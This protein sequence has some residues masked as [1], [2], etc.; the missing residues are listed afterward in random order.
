[1]REEWGKV[2]FQTFHDHIKEVRRRLLWVIL[3]IGVS[4]GIGYALRIPLIN[5]LQHP[6]GAPLYYTSPAGSFNFAIKISMIIGMFVALPVIIYQLIRFLEPA[7]PMRVKKGLMAKVIGSS[8]LLALTGIAFGYFYMIPMSLKFFAGY[9][10]AHIQPLISANE[11]L[12]YIINNLIIFALVFQIPLIV[13]FINRIKPLKPSKL[14]HY[15][16]HVVV[17]SFALA[18]ILPFTYDPISQFIVAI[19]IVVL[20]YLSAILLWVANRGRKPRPAVQPAIPV[21]AYQKPLLPAIPSPPPATSLPMHFRRPVRSI[22][23]FIHMPKPAVSTANAKLLATP[24][25]LVQEAKL[26]PAAKL[27]RPPL[28]IDGITPFFSTST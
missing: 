14:L 8:F 19:P 26:R 10:T 2:P 15:Q 23:G 24:K 25:L 22:D 7:L 9:S 28:A 6:L 11:Y 12:S 27:R 1:M 21:P 20:Y 4:A 3:A 17:G 5:V 13:L 16:R 18:I